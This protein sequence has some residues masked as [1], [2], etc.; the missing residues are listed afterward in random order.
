MSASERRAEIMRIL[1]G[2]RKCYLSDLAQE[3]GVSKEPFRETFRHLYCNTLLKVFMETAAE[4][5]LQ[6]GIIHIEIFCH[7]SKFERCGN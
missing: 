5:V 1:V 6:I 3:L 4:F 2:R 7:K